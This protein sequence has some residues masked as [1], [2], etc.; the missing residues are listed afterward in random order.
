MMVNHLIQR[1]P[2]PEP[3]R[4]YARAHSTTPAHPFPQN[5]CWSG[6]VCGVAF[7][8]AGCYAEPNEN[9]CYFNASAGGTYCTV[10]ICH[11]FDNGGTTCDSSYDSSDS[12]TSGSPGSSGT[13]P[14]SWWELLLF[15]NLHEFRLNIV[16][17]ELLIGL[18]Y[19]H[20]GL[21]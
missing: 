13:C 8:Q 15:R 5:D 21:E 1:H 11:G 3:S 7:E 12:T 9:D 6:L 10:C 4:V 19:S 16:C 14:S 20:V 2:L 18:S 17:F